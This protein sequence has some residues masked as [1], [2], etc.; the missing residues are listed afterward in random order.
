MSWLVTRLPRPD[1]AA[2]LFCLPPA[3]G[4]A[5]IYRAWPAAFDPR[6]EVQALQLPGRETRIGES[7]G[8][9]VA[10]IA[11]ALHAAADLPYAFF[12]HSMGARLAFEVV[13]RLRAEGGRLPL[14]LCVAGCRSPEVVAGG[15]LNGLSRLD[16]ETLVD[17]LC[18]EG[19]LPPEVA[20]NP[21]LRELV[22][23]ALRTDL[24]WVDDYRY[25]PQAPLPV[26]VVA[27]LG[28]DDRAVTPDQVS[29]WRHHT[30]AGY[31]Q[32]TV[33]GDHFFPY[34]PGGQVP[35]AVER[36]LLAAL[37]EMPTAGAPEGVAP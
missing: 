1:A 13:R 5:S 21:D 10:A 17:R 32:H 7:P 22:L 20:A 24:A 25:V 26:P 4:G 2:R 23:P 29:G 19:G 30:S 18:A 31:V 16:D 36:A 27:F 11:A 28:S 8:V 14:L 37:A 34:Q 9:D 12:G 15:P 35:G 33:P 3:G 6:I